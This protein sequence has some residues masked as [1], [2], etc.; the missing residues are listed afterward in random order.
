MALTGAAI[1]TL[2]VTAWADGDHPEEKAGMGWGTY[3]FLAFM[4]LLLL[5]WIIYFLQKKQLEELK[6]MKRQD[7]GTRDK[8]KQL[9]KRVALLRWIGWT[10]LMGLLLIGTLNVLAS[11]DKDSAVHMEHIHGLGYS[12]DGQRLLFA[13]HD[14]LKVYSNGHWS[15]GPGDKHDYMGFSVMD[16]GFYSSGHPAPGSK[17]KNPFGVVRSVDEGKSV[18]PLAYYGQIDFHL[19]AAGYKSHALYVYNPQPQA[20]MK[21][22]GLYYSQDEGKTWTK[23]DMKGLTGEVTALAAHPDQASTIV[24]GTV[25][26]AYLSKDFGK[27]FEAVVTGKQI[28]GLSYS[29]RGSLLA[30]TYVSNKP[31]LVQMASDSRDLKNLTVPAL[32][33]DAVAYIAVHP[34]NDQEISLVT[35]NRQAFT[36]TDGGGNWKQIVED[37][38]SVL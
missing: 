13:A 32:T 36:S 22:Q 14:G 7:T 17:L 9:T 34:R 8:N 5:S 21:E 20:Q 24:I 11:R 27:T 31:G 19:M 12:N 30:G 28:T 16:Q 38:E 18:E 33:E 6:N 25:S 29:P 2:P 3:L 10:S 37:G 1:F 4:V 15:A 35:F 23:S 26:G